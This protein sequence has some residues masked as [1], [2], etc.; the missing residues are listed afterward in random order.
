MEEAQSLFKSRKYDDA[1][2]QVGKALEADPDYADAYFLQGSIALKRKEF[3]LMEESFKQ[4]IEL[5]PEVDPE[6]YFQLGWLYYDEKNYKNAEEQLKKFLSFD[7]INEDHASKAELF[8][9]RSSLYA[10]PVPFDP[11]PVRS[12]STADPEYLPAISPD[13]EY[14]FFTRRFEQK[15]KDM[16]VP[17]S[18]E[19][20]MIAKLQ[21]DGTYDKGKQMD[22]PFNAAA[23]NNEGGAAI[24]IDNKHLFFT[25][26]S[27]G[28]FD[29]CSSDF[30]E[31]HWSEITSLGKAVNDPVQWDSQPSVSSDGKTIYFASA[32]DSI[33]GIDIYVTH[34][35]ESGHWSRAVKLNSPINTN[36]NDKSPFIHSDSKT[37]Y[38]SS[39]SLPGLGGFD[40]FM[41]KKGDDGKW[42]KPVNLGYPINTDADEVGFFVSLDGKRGYFASNKLN[43]ELE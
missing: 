10:H 20:F 34:K 21:P 33:T 16:L 35:D 12:I 29:V 11:K 38:F 27:K 7:R 9:I 25:V 24:T 18:V 40:I 17:K 14:V 41:S 4:A 28:N 2:K 31:G 37:L 30:I 22:P 36:G 6:A 26:N 32:R 13:N 5:C 15:D 42:G 39:D 3:S 8:L 19:K 23:S 1:L 43:K